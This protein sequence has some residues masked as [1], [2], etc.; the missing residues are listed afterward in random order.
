MSRP[1]SWTCLSV[2]SD[3]QLGLTVSWVSWVRSPCQ[4]GLSVSRVCLSVRSP[5]Q[6][7]LSVSGLV[8]SYCAPAECL[9]GLQLLCTCRVF[10]WSA[11]TVHLPSVCLVCNYCAP[12]KC[13]SGLQL[14]CTCRVFGPYASTLYFC[15]CSEYTNS[16]SRSVL[17]SIFNYRRL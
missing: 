6:S 11:I 5:C 4:S 7:G 10:V 1:V 13:L 14:L 8:C 12:A 2:G 9:L 3:C 15:T 16:I 17:I